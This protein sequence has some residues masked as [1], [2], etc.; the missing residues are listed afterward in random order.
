MIEIEEPIF[1]F[2]LVN[3]IIF[4][5]K[6]WSNTTHNNLLECGLYMHISYHIHVDKV[7]QKTL[8]QLEY[9]H[10]KRNTYKNI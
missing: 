10:K 9:S 6:N 3:V 1:I 4:G 7:K 2:I 5:A 8:L